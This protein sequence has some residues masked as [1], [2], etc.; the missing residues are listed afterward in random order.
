[1]SKINRRDFIKLTGSA[2]V[3]GMVVGFPQIVGA[4][5]KKVVIVGGG[6]GGSTAAKYIRMADSSVEVTLVEP[7]AD[8]HTCFMSNEVLAGE[9]SI[10]SIRFTYEGLKSHGVNVV[11]DSVTAIDPAART[12]TTAG[13]QTLSY[14][15]CIV[16]PGI[17]LLYDSVPGY[18]AEVAETVPHAWKAGPQTVTLRKQLEAMPDGGTVVIVAPPNPFRCPPGPY[19]RASLIAHYLKHNKPKSKLLILDPKDKFSKQG[20]FTAGWK[21]FYGYGT[22]N[23]MIEWIS[24]AAGGKVES[25]DAGSMTLQAAVES[26]KGDVINII[27]AQRAGTIAQTAG[28]T[29][30]SG[31]CPVNP[32]TFE[33]TVHAGIHVVGDASIA[34]PLPKSGY[35]A[36]SEAKVCAAAVVDLLNGREPGQPSYVNTCYS[37][38][39][40]D[41]GISVAA[42]YRL[43]EDGKIASVEGAGGLTPGDASEEM[44]KR[45][46]TFAHSWFQ[47]ITHDTFG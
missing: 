19:E 18:S 39:G 12:V 2:A 42:V 34:S 13:G 35:A 8:Y 31:W 15:R 38:V 43:G 6:I 29:D 33:S 21:K 41:H 4:A 40:K 5:G 9:R 7:N 45:E 28:L 27:P 25:F 16:S 37:I 47:N 46:V 17:S 23:S 36:N 32:K 22:D 3:A 44:L 1:M 11:K 10:D 20:L 24:G 30:D 26:Y 14:D